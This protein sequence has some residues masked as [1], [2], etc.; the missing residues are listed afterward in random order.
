MYT[1]N[2]QICQTIYLTKHKQLRGVWGRK[3]ITPRQDL[4]WP[5]CCAN[6]F[7]LFQP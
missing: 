2:Y 1:T 6:H 4:G 3:P 5:L 7:R